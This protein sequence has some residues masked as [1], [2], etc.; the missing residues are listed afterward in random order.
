MLL[1]KNSLLM[2]SLRY[3]NNTQ[4]INKIIDLETNFNS[5]NSFKQTILSIAYQYKNEQCIIDRLIKM[6]AK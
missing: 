5:V 4:V 3:R 2:L 6:G 1:Q